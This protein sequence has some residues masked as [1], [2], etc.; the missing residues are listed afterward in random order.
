ML[1]LKTA[2]ETNFSLIEGV[3]FALSLEEMEAQAD[4]AERDAGKP[5]LMDH[6]Y[7]D[8]WEQQLIHKFG[9]NV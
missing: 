1:K 6:A 5:I 4:D 7:F 3:A 9:K 2:T 8:Q